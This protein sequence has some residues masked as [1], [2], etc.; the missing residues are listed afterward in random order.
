MIT[1]EVVVEL[2]E[3]LSIRLINA[4]YTLCLPR[5]PIMPPYLLH[6]LHAVAHSSFLGL[7]IP[8]LPDR[9]LITCWGNFF[10][11]PD[12]SCLTLFS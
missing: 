4:I 5:P 9:L 7:P 12:N 1:P 6:H 3:I 2:N 8:H 10:N 11:F